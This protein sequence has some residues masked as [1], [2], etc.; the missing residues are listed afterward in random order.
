MLPGKAQ[1]DWTQQQHTL[2]IP[3][4]GRENTKNFCLGDTTSLMHDSINNSCQH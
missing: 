4:Y 3:A 2:G 1:V